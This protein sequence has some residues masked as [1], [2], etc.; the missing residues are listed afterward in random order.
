MTGYSAADRDSDDGEHFLLALSE[1]SNSDSLYQTDTIILGAEPNQ[2]I[3]ESLNNVSDH[4]VESPWMLGANNSNYTVFS[5]TTPLDELDIRILFWI[6]Y[7]II[8][9]SCVLGK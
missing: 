3:S 9:T 4:L 1:L 2:S 7:V 5:F 6:I 8:A